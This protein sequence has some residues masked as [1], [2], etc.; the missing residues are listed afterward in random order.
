MMNGRMFRV[1]SLVIAGLC[2][3]R[4]L[5]VSAATRDNEEVEVYSSTEESGDSRESEAEYNE[6][7]LTRPDEAA[8]RVAD[9]SYDQ[10]RGVERIKEQERAEALIVPKK[11]GRAIAS[12]PVESVASPQPTT[13]TLKASEPLA[14]GLIEPKPFTATEAQKR[15]SELHSENIVA[16]SKPAYGLHSEP[17]ASVQIESPV[18]LTSAGGRAGTQEISLIVSDYGYF[19]N[20]LFVTQNVPVKIYLTT[21]SKVTLCFMLDQWGVKK[22]VLPGKVEEISFVPEAPGEYRF[23]CPV[24]SIEGTLV[25]R[26]TPIASPS[27]R[28]IAAEE[29]PTAGVGN[30]PKRAAALRQLIED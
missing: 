19:P 21:P 8:E 5:T 11:S 1:M 24:K 28:G 30:E 9:Q 2:M 18:P 20:R 14:A 7:R 23:Y 3:V 29:P 10:V 6:I 17:R 25:V 16:S 22:G 13:A 15:A 4:V 27:A 26:E 12:M